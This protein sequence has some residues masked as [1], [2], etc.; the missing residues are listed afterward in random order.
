MPADPIPDD[1]DIARYAG[2][3]KI[4]DDGRL[5]RAAF[6]LRSPREEYLSVFCLDM[7]EGDDVSS[8]IEYLK[9]DMPLAPSPNGKL[10]VINV[11][12]M[13]KHVEAE[14][15]DNRK[16]RV[17]HEP[18]ANPEIPELNRD[19]HCGVRGI[20]YDDGVIESILAECVG[21][22]YPISDEPG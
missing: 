7:I 15:A 2:P 20:K 6:R 5:S 16:L 11:G 4:D 10:G 14:S 12:H 21:E 18:E 1:S 9:K 13:K 17:T 3:S 22:C 8:R 19:Y